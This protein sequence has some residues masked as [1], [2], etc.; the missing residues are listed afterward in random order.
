MRHPGAITPKAG[1][2]P[3]NP[4]RFAHVAPRVRERVAEQQ[5]LAKEDQQ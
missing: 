5:S 4:H 1:R 3:A 2:A